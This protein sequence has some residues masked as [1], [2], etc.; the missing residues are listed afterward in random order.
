[1]QTYDI[2]IEDGLIVD[3]SGG[4]PYLGNVAIQADKIVA[5]GEVAGNGRITIKADGQAVSPGFINMM[6]WANESLILDG[7]SQ[8]DIRQGVTLEVLGE[9]HSMGP[10]NDKLKAYMKARQGDFQYDIEWNTLDEYL[11]FLTRRGVSPNVSSFVGAGGIRAYVLGFDDRR[12]TSDELAQMQTLVRRAM[13][14]GALGISSALIYAPDMYADTAEL[15]ALAQ[16]TAE[17]DGIYITHLRSEGARFLEAL[18]E[19]FTIVEQAKIRGEIYHLKAAGPR[20]WHKMEEVIR[21][22]EEK[23]AAGWP[24]TADMYPYHASSTGLD[25]IMP[26]WALDGGHEAWIARLKDPET[27]VRILADLRYT[28]TDRENPFMELETTDNI[29]FTA[30]KNDALKPYS[31]KTLTEVGALRGKDPLETALDLIVEDDSRV[32]TV[33]FS[34]SEENVR[35]E[36]GLPWV[37]FCSDSASL[38]TEGLFLKYHPHPRS[39]GA[40]AR[41]FAKYVRAE[42]V[43]SLAEAVRRMT[44]LPA[45]NLKLDR[46]GRLQ[47]G[48][49]AD[50]VIFDPET[51]QDHATFARPH[52]YATGVQHVLVNGVPVIQDG[53]HTG[54]TPG[55]V[56]R[57]PGWQGRKVGK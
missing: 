35:R 31:G 54:A 7:R 46:R 21:R 13:A 15:I 47:P 2:L 1:M 12:P 49:F 18:E 42:N 44:A 45:A 11:Q 51:I 39:Y 10:V 20:N 38:A 6:C 25:A 19:F 28:G 55:R 40:F 57:G 48:H 26:G 27:R 34:M 17:Y 8:S 16:A 3:G 41:V 5:L 52:Q 9:G 56:V 32:G 30:F 23:Q 33:F 53:D 22:V 36:V 50:V 43:I 14:E 37:S 29:L 24:I 4:E